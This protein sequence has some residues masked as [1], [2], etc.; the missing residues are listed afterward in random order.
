MDLRKQRSTSDV[1][2]ERDIVQRSAHDIKK[3]FSAGQPIFNF[4]SS[5]LRLSRS[6]CSKIAKGLPI[7]I[8][9]GIMGEAFSNKSAC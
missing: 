2:V 9:G 7:F 6:K 3:E 1:Y 5:K 8:K 4:S